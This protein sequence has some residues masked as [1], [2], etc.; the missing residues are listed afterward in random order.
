MQCG[1]KTPLAITPQR[2][3]HRNRYKKMGPLI[4]LRSANWK[5]SK[6]CMKH[7]YRYKH[8]LW[9]KLHNYATTWLAVFINQRKKNVTYCITDSRDLVFVATLGQT[10]PRLQT[11]V[12][13]STITRPQLRD[14]TS[15]V[16]KPTQINVTYVLPTDV[17]WFLPSPCKR[18]RD[19]KQTYVKERRCR[20]LVEVDSRPRVRD[21]HE[22]LILV[23]VLV[24]ADMF[25]LVMRFW[26]RG[27]KSLEVSVLDQPGREFGGNLADVTERRV[28][29]ALTQVICRYHLRQRLTRHRR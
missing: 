22:G 2:M 11:N 8:Y 10:L 4:Q 14:V 13:N 12:W 20:R 19:Y 24:V 9:W 17:V 6:N 18:L 5:K 15:S 7:L 16:H 23:V 25:L 28:D 21:R 3:S 1:K 29:A 26:V 27:R